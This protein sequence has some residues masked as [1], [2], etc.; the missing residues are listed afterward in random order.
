M[1]GRDPDLPDVIEG[2][3]IQLTRHNEMFEFGGQAT[4]MAS[5]ISLVICRPSFAH[6]ERRLSQCA[7]VDV[8]RGVGPWRQVTDQVGEWFRGWTRG[9][10]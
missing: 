3:R 1:R 10:E 4:G 6:A 8:E 9:R 5:G 7:R 2:R